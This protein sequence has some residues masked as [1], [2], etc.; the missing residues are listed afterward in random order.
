MQ[1]KELICDES[2]QCL[3]KGFNREKSK[4]NKV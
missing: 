3:P 1:L 4:T 2:H